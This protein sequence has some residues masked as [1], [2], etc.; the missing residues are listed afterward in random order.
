MYITC[1]FY[2]CCMVIKVQQYN[3]GH[4]VEENLLHD[5]MQLYAPQSPVVK[6]ERD[7]T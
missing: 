6:V 4:V 5:R 1:R 2:S 7:H 3:L